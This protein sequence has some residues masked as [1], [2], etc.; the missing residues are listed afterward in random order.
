MPDNTFYQKW[1]KYKELVVNLFT[2]LKSN[3]L[4]G[5]KLSVPLA[6]FYEGTLRTI[7]VIRHDYPDFLCDFHFNLVNSLPEHCIQLKNIVLSA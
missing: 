5:Q 3:M 1:F 4:A 6:K 2:F 7:L